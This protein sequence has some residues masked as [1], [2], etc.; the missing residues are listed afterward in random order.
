[1]RKN[2][3]LIVDDSA[4]SRK[5]LSELVEEGKDLKVAFAASKASL[6]YNYLGK[7]KVSLVI[8]DV[9]MPEIDGIEAAGHISKTWP[10][11][12]I[13]MCS[14]VNEAA[15]K[16]SV[17]ALEAGATDFIPKPTSKSGLDAFKA[18][19]HQKIA[20]LIQ[21]AQKRAP[22]QS[23]SPTPINKAKGA[24]KVALGGPFATQLEAIT[25]GCSTGGPVALSEFFNC[26]KAPFPVPTFI[27]QHMP[28]V[29]TRLLAERLAAK[30]G[31]TIKEGEH[32]EEALAGVTYIAPGGKHMV[33]ARKKT[34]V[35][36]EL[37][38]GPQEHSCRPAVDVLFRSIAQVYRDRSVAAVFTGMGADGSGG[39]A[40]LAKA[41]CEVLVQ[42][43]ST[44]VVPSMP[45]ASLQAGNVHQVLTLKEIAQ[46]FEQR[47]SLLVTK[48]KRAL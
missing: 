36:I 21:G 2:D 22:A 11:I 4:V 32:G 13:L 40:A 14:G 34:G 29:F 44:C 15:A 30:T 47:C 45:Q 18:S 23:S 12:P 8:L 25:I 27:V 31:F 42:D 35:F 5:V 41:G 10:G 7:N 1:M 20:A 16:L 6:A 48:K 39:T 43:P 46:R 24:Y 33:V 19:L 17:K 38:E 28:P 9:N 26:V 3:V 37:N